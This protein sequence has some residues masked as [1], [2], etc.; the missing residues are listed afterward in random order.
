MD[1]ARVSDEDLSPIYR[2][3]YNRVAALPEFL[4]LEE[5]VHERLRNVHVLHHEYRKY[6]WDHR[7]QCLAT[8]VLGDHTQD[9]KFFVKGAEDDPIFKLDVSHLVSK[10]EVL[11][12][13]FNNVARNGKPICPHGLVKRDTV[14]YGAA[15][16]NKNAFGPWAIYRMLGSG[17]NQNLV[18]RTK[19]RIYRDLITKLTS[20]PGFIQFSEDLQM[21][22]IIGKFS[23]YSHLPPELLH[24]AIDLMYVKATMEK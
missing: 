5:Q 1:I 9:I 23:N 20:D 3:L 24:R 4:A 19:Q 6:E 18:K 17:P 16:R 15:P 21:D 2:A 10:G 22:D 14:K 12:V 13:Y 7:V 11:R 8:V